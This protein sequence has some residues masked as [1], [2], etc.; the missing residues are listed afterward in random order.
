MRFVAIHK[1]IV[2]VEVVV[3]D[4][5]ALHGLRVEI[6]AAVSVFP[7]TVAFI[8]VLLFTDRAKAVHFALVPPASVSL[9]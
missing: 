5:D 6:S 3:S 7:Q 4:L 9:S 2:T 1:R 8:G